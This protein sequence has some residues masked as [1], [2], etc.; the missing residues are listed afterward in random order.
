[1]ENKIS[2]FGY[3]LIRTEVLKNVL[4][5]N[6]NGLLYWAGKELSRSHKTDS[7]YDATEFFSK[8]DWGNLSLIKESK[9]EIKYHL[10]GDLVDFRLQTKDADFNLETGFLA[11]QV[12][13]KSKK[14]TE[15]TCN[16][17]VKKRFVEIIVKSDLK[18]DVEG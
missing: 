17:N 4:G 9:D 5:K 18:D 11:A 8:A 6:A 2:L 3:E 13:L 14:R 12:E 10:T 16:I 7:E 15:A 1:M